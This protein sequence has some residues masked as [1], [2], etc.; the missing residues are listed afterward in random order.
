MG[1]NITHEKLAYLK[2]LAKMPFP[3][4]QEKKILHDL[5]EILNYF[6]EL[7][8]V[9]TEDVIPSAGG[10]FNT[11]IFR[12]DAAEKEFSDTHTVGQ[13]PEAHGTLLCMP[14]V[15]GNEE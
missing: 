14:P 5:G 1:N 12:V 6:Q 11:S 3:E 2:E 15:F 4:E 7:Q 10:S 9:D 8:K 13:F